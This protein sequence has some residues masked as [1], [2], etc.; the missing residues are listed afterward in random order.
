MI[1]YCSDDGPT[2][3]ETSSLK[4]WQDKILASHWLE[5]NQDEFTISHSALSS[6]CCK[7]DQPSG[8]AAYICFVWC[9][10]RQTTS[11]GSEPVFQCLS[12]LWTRHLLLVP[13]A[14]KPFPWRL[15]HRGLVA[16]GCGEK[17]REKGNKTQ[18]SQNE[19]MID[20]D[21]LIWCS[22][23]CLHNFSHVQK[24]QKKDIG[25]RFSVSRNGGRMTSEW[26]WNEF[27]HY[28]VL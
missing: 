24:T 10:A 7:L 13:R 20:D 3:S 12:N 28:L 26:G 23:P 15:T 1:S 21:I 18:T 5:A 17:K 25:L 6:T 9:P 11:G 14:W 4:P 8:C 16:M 19:L 27:V 2:W 22:Q